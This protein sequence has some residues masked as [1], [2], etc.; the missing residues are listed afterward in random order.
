[1]LIWLVA[2][3]LGGLTVLL[4]AGGSTR[5]AQRVGRPG[6][7]THLAV[8]KQQLA[9][10]ERDVARGVL[11]ATEAAQQKTEVS[12]RLLA[13]ARDPE[14]GTAA[15]SPLLAWL[16]ALLVPAVALLL[17]A[18][19]GS[20][21]LPDLPQAERLATA[22]AT[23]DL[24]ALVYKVERHLAVNPDDATGW[25]IL[26]P[27]YQS[28]NRYDGLA[29]AYENLIRIKG[30]SAPLQAGLAEAL[31]LGNGG[32]MTPAGAAAARAA[33]ALD[34][35][36]PQARYFN[37][38]GLAQEG[39]ATEALAAYRALLADSAA[40]APW[41]TAVHQRISDLEAQKGTVPMPGQEQ[42]GSVLN[43][44]PSDQQ[45]MIRGMVDGLAARLE[46]N[47]DDLDGWSR[48]IRAR[49]VLQE[50]DVAQGALDKA[51]QT[52]AGN[53]PALDSLNSLATE[54]KLK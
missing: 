36:N 45:A 23:G 8:Y 2:A 16:S 15:R 18:H 28:L 6:R 24:D 29:N 27:V 46:S 9:E 31:T 41:R 38:L 1:M 50:L 35:M 11:G 10:I 21:R 32:V 48:L 4:L 52:F 34:P 37:A 26:L 12:R 42:A 7:E 3:A 39:K 14:T 47:P 17:Y 54:L 44:S 33:V 5:L 22:E 19:Y 25:D 53:P 51:R 49:S 13:A 43:Q 30:S 40:D 20:P